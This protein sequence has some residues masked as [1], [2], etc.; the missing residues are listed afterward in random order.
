MVIPVMIIVVVFVEIMI[1]IGVVMYM[2]STGMI[3]LP[4]CSRPM[5]IGLNRIHGMFYASREHI[6]HITDEL[7]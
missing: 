3:Y 4:R 2:N 7:D 6:T 1:T 5:S